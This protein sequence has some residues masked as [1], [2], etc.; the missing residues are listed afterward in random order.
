MPGR[1]QHPTDAMRAHA[2]WER[3]LEDL[4][5]GQDRLEG[6]LRETQR[7]LTATRRAIR[8]ITALN[9]APKAP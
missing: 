8:T 5:A 3:Q 2:H 7:R 9:G 6:E 1:A 4:R